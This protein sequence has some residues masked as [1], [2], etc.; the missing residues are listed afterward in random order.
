MAMRTQTIVVLRQ[1]LLS[2]VAA[3]IAAVTFGAID[4][5]V[6]GVTPTAADEST[7]TTTW[8]RKAESA[9]STAVA[10]GSA[11]ASRPQS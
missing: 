5:A 4:A 8:D 9:L 10:R 6:I 11:A 2:L 3:G 7:T 1:L